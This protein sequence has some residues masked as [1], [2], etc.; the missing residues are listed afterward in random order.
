MKSCS[1]SLNNLKDELD[2]LD[3]TK[4]QTALTYLKKLMIL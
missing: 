3:I 1:N 2:K 4:L